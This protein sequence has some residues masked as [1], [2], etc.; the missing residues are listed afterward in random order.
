[1]WSE[2][3]AFLTLH[4]F[5]THSVAGD[6]STSNTCSDTSD[7][8]DERMIILLAFRVTFVVPVSHYVGGCEA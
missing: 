8:N 4:T 3:T 2:H 5:H 1:L 7:E 6:A